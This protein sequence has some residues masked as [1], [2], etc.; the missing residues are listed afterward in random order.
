MQV[1]LLGSTVVGVSVELSRWVFGP[2][3]PE[4]SA[5]GDCASNRLAK[6]CTMTKHDASAATGSGDDGM[7]TGPSYE[8]A[9][10]FGDPALELFGN[11]WALSRGP[12]T[13]AEYTGRHRAPDA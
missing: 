1:T 8:S 4:V 3:L 6:E 12:A 13:N 5:P 7:P 9:S 11:G 10:R 2:S